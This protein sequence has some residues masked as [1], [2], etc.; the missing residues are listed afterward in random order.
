MVAR[1]SWN[2]QAVAGRARPIDADL[3]LWR[4]GAQGYGLAAYPQAE[5]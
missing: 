5:K 4:Y 3:D 2:K 1:R